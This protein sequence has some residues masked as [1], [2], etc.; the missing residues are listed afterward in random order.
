MILLGYFFGH[1]LHVIEKVVGVGG[2]IAVVI[3]AIVGLG[4]WRRYEHQKVHAH[5]EPAPTPDA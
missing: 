2:V 5:D 1:S 3:A 4:F